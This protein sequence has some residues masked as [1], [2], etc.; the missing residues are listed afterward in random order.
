MTHLWEDYHS[1]VIGQVPMYLRPFINIDVRSVKLVCAF[2]RHALFAGQNR[3]KEKTRWTN[4]VNKFV[5]LEGIVSS[6]GKKCV[7]PK[8]CITKWRRPDKTANN[9]NHTELYSPCNGSIQIKFI[10]A[11]GQLA[12]NNAKIK[13]I[14]STKTVLQ[15]WWPRRD[16]SDGP[17]RVNFMHLRF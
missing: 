17:N 3:T 5:T 2:A 1:V 4:T 7:R 6:I 8:E 14:K 10:N 13:K 12:T 9:T 15:V 16:L 11:K